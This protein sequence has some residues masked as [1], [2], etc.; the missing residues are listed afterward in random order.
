MAVNRNNIPQPLIAE[1]IEGLAASPQAFADELCT[2]QPVPS[3]NGTITVEPSANRLGA[4]NMQGGIAEGAEA[5]EFLMDLT[6][7]TYACLR[8]E[9]YAV[10]PDGTVIDSNAAG[11][12]LL[13][14]ALEGALI[15][16]N[17]KL[18]QDLFTSLNTTT[19]TAAAGNGTWTTASST[20][21]EDLQDLF[22]VTADPNQLVL[23]RQQCQALQV[24]PDFTSRVSNYAGGAIGVG[25][26]ANILRDVFPHLENVYM[27]HRLYNDQNAGQAVSIS[28][29]SYIFSNLVWAGHKSDCILCEPPGGIYTEQDRIIRKQSDEILVGRRAD[30]LLPHN[31]MNGRL[32]GTV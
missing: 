17:I 10:L 5:Q 15:R 3:L 9:A 22:D 20:P 13:A 21:F 26:V 14:R 11:Y 25:M 32:T 8:Y 4:G 18:D 12:Q 23:G 31:E 24:H 28:A 29:S 6:S 16:A 7:T 27:N 19:T 2:K 1:V 30:I